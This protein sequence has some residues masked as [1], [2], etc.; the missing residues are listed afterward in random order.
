M[1]IVDEGRQLELADMWAR[2]PWRYPFYSAFVRGLV[3][4]LISASGAFGQL[5]AASQPY[6]G[7]GRVRHW[8]GLGT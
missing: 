1:K 4:T 7:F 5:S 2:D 3:Y 8:H 6:I